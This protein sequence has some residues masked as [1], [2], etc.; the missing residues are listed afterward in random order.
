M[1]FN[2][3]K[4]GGGSFGNDGS[5]Q[6]NKKKKK[7]VSHG[8]NNFAVSKSLGKRR[9]CGRMRSNVEKFISPET[10]ANC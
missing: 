3:L 2:N 6:L 1:L 8:E 7:A 5:R 9:R 10:A 4:F